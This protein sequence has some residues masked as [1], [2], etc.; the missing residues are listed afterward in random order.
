MAKKSRTAGTPANQSDLA[1]SNAATRA[2]LPALGGNDDA[3][4]VLDA[5]PLV[6]EDEA[7][8][9]VL[10][11]AA[12]AAHAEA[13]KKAAASA[14]AAKVSAKAAPSKQA[15]AA[16]FG[17]NN[18]EPT[19]GP[20][21]LDVRMLWRGDTH[22]ARFFPRPVPVTLGEDGTFALPPDSMGK[23]DGELT[24]LVEPH[25]TAGFA[26]RIDNPAAQGHL[27]IDGKSYELAAVRAGTESVKGPSIPITAK[28]HAYVQFDD[29]TFLLS[30]TA[31]PP[32]PPISLWS[33]ENTIFL[34]CLLLALAFLGGPLFAGFNSAEFRNRAKLSYLDQVEQDLRKPEL[35][36]VLV[37]EDKVQEEKKDDAKEDD[38][39]SDHWAS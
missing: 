35:I 29:F 9:T 6:E 30:R 13:T 16:A 24:L 10:D 8:T 39:E 12:V 37:Q 26:L 36:E 7:A 27:L 25:A 28:T 31:V 11:V 38:D 33:R 18:D 21:G 22:A 23:K 14:P 2:D 20:L 15:A 4:V 3:T 19:T 32:P 1:A 17:S 5:I 34:L